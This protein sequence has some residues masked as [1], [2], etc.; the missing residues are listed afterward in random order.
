[1]GFDFMLEELL[2]VVEDIP[3]GQI[4]FAKDLIKGTEWG[5][6]PKGDRSKFGKYFKKKVESGEIPGVQY[7][8]KADNNSAKYQKI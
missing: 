1:M 7:L 4:F 8:E 3:S 5:E 6:L 2:Q